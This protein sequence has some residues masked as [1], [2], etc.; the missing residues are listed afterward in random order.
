MD[1]TEEEL[2]NWEREWNIPNKTEISFCGEYK[3]NI[4]WKVVWKNWKELKYIFRN[5]NRA[6]YV[7][8]SIKDSKTQKRKYKELRITSLMKRYFWPYIDGYANSEMEKWSWKVFIVVPKDGVWENMELRNLMIVERR[9][10]NRKW[11]KREKIIILLES[12]PKMIDEEIAKSV[13]WKP[14]SVNKIRNELWLNPVEW[15]HTKFASTEMY[16]A[17]IECDWKKPNLEIAKS[18]W[19]DVNFDDYNTQK[20]YT[21]RL[22]RARKR[23]VDEWK[24]SKYNN[25][26]DIKKEELAEYLIE[27]AKLEKGVRKTHAQIADIFELTKY[28]VD[29]FSR[30]LKKK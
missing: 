29:N 28:Q 22:A 16:D 13:W 23:L 20:R 19:S 12:C 7:S 1:N 3:I 11:T 10:Y 6:P 9:E 14:N 18:L 17:L 27:N 5:S 25:S 4:N 24:I 8:I 30:T 2:K 26:L 21:N 15:M